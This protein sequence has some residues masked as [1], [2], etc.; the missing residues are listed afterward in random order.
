MSCLRPA[1][2]L[3]GRGGGEHRAADLAALRGL[4]PRHVLTARAAGP[5]S[6]DTARRGRAARPHRRH[7]PRHVPGPPAGAPRRTDTQQLREAAQQAEADGGGA[8]DAA[9]CSAAAVHLRVRRSAGAHL[10]HQGGAAAGA[11][12]DPQ[13][14]VRRQKSPVMSVCVDTDVCSISGWVPDESDVQNK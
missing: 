10:H 14:Q 8:S 3:P 2:S 9:H 1:E 11:A 4:L 6:G 13:L 5:A 7:R 12:G